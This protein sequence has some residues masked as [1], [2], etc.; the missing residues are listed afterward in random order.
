M[1][2]DSTI[3]NQPRNPLILIINLLFRIEHI[4]TFFAESHS[5][6]LGLLLHIALEVMAAHLGT[7][8]LGG[9]PQLS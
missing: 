6:E 2:T 9:P 3:I 5:F 7:G 4:V 1:S 8:D